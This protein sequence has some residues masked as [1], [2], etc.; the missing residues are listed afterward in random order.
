VPDHS[1][2]VA[3]YVVLEKLDFGQGQDIFVAATPTR[4]G[5][6]DERVLLKIVSGVAGDGQLHRAANELRTFAM[7]DSPYL[8]QLLDAGQDRDRVF[9][10]MAYPALGTLERPHRPL[11]DHESMRAVACAAR[12]AHALHESGIVHRNITPA[13]VLLNETRAKLANLGMAKPLTHEVSVSRLPHVA[14]IEYLDPMIMLGNRH[15]RATDIWSLGVVLHW[16]L[17]DGSPIHPGRSESDPFVAVRQVLTEPPF[18]SSKLSPEVV[19]IVMGALSADA[20]E[21]PAT[22]ELF[23]QQIETLIGADS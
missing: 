12:G 4:L 8:V 17:S 14:D 13:N 2:N 6:D 20:S 15:S 18:L 16:A 9:Y 1:Y 3:D 7:V 21:R 23:A 10:A 5:L 22:A 11:T 19:R